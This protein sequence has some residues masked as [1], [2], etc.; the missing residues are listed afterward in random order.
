MTA[1]SLPARIVYAVLAFPLGAAAG[2]Y[3]STPLFIK[4][5]PLFHDPYP[6]ME[7]F[8]VFVMALGVGAASG[9]TVF[10]VALTLP[11]KRRRKRRG[12]AGRAI[13]AA[14]FILLAS[15]FLADQGN[16][17]IYDLAIATWLA[18]AMS[19]TFVR[20]GVLDQPRRTAT[21]GR[22]S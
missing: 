9:L 12:R 17:L 10:L 7:G 15:L 14:L 8:G 1:V 5:A 6:S 21:P 2:F 13:F 3:L 4:L 16:A 19:F 20:Y 11:W 18:L 22:A